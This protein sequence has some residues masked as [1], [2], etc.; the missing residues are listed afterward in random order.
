[1]STPLPAT[2]AATISR[3]GTMTPP[4][5]GDIPVLGGAI[6]LGHGHHPGHGAAD[7]HGPGAGEAT[8]PA[9]I[10]VLG[11]GAGD[12]HMCPLAHTMPPVP[13]ATVARHI[14]P[15]KAQLAPLPATMGTMAIPVPAIARQ[16]VHQAAP[17]LHTLLAAPIPAIPARVTGMA[18]AATPTVAQAPPITQA[19]PTVAQA[20][21]PI[22]AVVAA[23]L[24]VA[25]VME[26]VA[27]EAA[28]AAVHAADAINPRFLYYYLSNI[29]LSE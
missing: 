17:T 23:D 18:P 25:A 5:I 22:A 4:G 16:P 1:M 13:P 9:I 11:A 28:V 15:A 29:T 26:A 21:R 6:T 12:P 27:P 20:P 2:G 19:V 8:I 24:H 10:P 14:V 7:P 3:P